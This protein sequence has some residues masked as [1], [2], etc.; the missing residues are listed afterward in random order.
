MGSIRYGAK[1]PDQ[2]RNRELEATSVDTW[3]TTLTAIY[4]TDPD[5]IA[6][7]LPQPLRPSPSNRWSASRSRPSTSAVAV[8]RSVP[9]RSRSRRCTATWSVATRW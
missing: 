7:V 1:S 4:E 3:A 5:A 8:H 6:A 9:A 2:L